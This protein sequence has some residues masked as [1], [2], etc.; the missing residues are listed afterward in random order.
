MDDTP[1]LG[2]AWENEKRQRCAINRGIQQLQ[3]E[4]G[5]LIAISDVDEILDPHT[6]TVLKC[7]GVQDLYSFGQGLFYYNLT[8]FLCLWTKPKILPFSMYRDEYKGDCE[9]IRMTRILKNC[10]VIERGGWHMSYFGSPTFIQNKIK[11]FSH[12]ECN[13]DENTKLEVIEERV[14]RGES[15]TSSQ[16]IRKIPLEQNSYLPPNLDLYTKFFGKSE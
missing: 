16:K 15:C 5:D 11:N 7:V 13:T 6:L 9:T 12:Q 2:N 14:K 4:G 10:K 3:L 8:N 1:V